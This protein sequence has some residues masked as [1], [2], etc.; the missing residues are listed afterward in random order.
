MQQQPPSRPGSAADRVW[1]PPPEGATRWDR[2][3]GIA[4]PTNLDVTSAEPGFRLSAATV[5][6]QRR[7]RRRQRWLRVRPLVLAAVAFVVGVPAVIAGAW[8][9]WQLGL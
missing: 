6:A 5:E 4:R 8:L 9:I 7:Y 2:T 3:R 1:G